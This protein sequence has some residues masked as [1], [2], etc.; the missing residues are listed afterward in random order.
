MPIL[1][2]KLQTQGNENEKE[3][4]RQARTGSNAMWYITAQPELHDELL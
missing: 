2:L 3:E 4:K 1:Y